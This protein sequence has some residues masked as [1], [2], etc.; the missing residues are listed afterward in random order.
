MFYWFI[1]WFCLKLI[2][3]IIF[4]IKLHNLVDESFYLVNK[5][6]YFVLFKISIHLKVTHTYSKN[7]K[8]DW[9]K[10]CDCE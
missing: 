1:D 10:N 6:H 7:L 3:L 4:F 9:V 5:I 2:D 8:S